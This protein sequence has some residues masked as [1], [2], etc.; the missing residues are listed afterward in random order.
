VGKFRKGRVYLAYKE[1]HSMYF[2]INPK[3]RKEG[4]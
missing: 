1:E 4:K 3:E 2:A